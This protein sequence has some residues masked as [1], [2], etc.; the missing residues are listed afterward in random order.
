M[1]NLNWTQFLSNFECRFHDS[2]NVV[3][4][5]IIFKFCQI[6]MNTLSKGMSTK[7][8]TIQTW[9]LCSIWQELCT[10]QTDLRKIQAN[11]VTPI[12]CRCHGRETRFDWGER[13]DSES[14]SASKKKTPKF[15]FPCLN[16]NP[17]PL[18]WSHSSQRSVQKK[19]A[20][21]QKLVSIK[22]FHVSWNFSKHSCVFLPVKRLTPICLKCGRQKTWRKRILH[23]N[24][25]F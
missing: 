16:S 17:S 7:V 13:K 3:V 24:A 12:S 4:L 8:A 21:P 25:M 22:V 23:Q 2:F 10:I 1:Q 6:F 20:L 14:E 11:S 5:R 18:Q 19:R 9:N 15:H